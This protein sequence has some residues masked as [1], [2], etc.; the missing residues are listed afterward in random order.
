MKK[1]IQQARV[2]TSRD[3]P[4]D[5]VASLAIARSLL[6]GF[7]PL[8]NV[9]S[10]LFM[11]PNFG[12]RIFFFHSPPLH[13]NHFAIMPFKVYGASIYYSD[14]YERGKSRNSKKIIYDD[15]VWLPIFGVGLQKGL[16]KVNLPRKKEKM[17]MIIINIYS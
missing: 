6:I 14:K 1:M 17:S 12:S 3:L 10:S 4:H 2:R 15:Q 11:V 7:L 13:S 16:F 8:G 5:F 9:H